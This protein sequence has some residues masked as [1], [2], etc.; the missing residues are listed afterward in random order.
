MDLSRR[1]DL[2]DRRFRHADLVQSGIN[3]TY[4]I[5]GD[6]EPPRYRVKA[7]GS[8][9]RRPHRCGS[10]TGQTD[11]ITPRRAIMLHPARR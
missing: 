5:D 4:C 11:N 10:R 2:Y 8:N 6:I 7:A 9:R 3:K 1:F